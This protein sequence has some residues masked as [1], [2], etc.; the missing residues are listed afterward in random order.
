MHPVVKEKVNTMALELVSVNDVQVPAKVVKQTANQKETRK[1]IDDL[2]AAGPEIVGKITVEEGKMRSV[3]MGFIHGFKSATDK[4][5]K[6][7]MWESSDGGTLFIQV[8]KADAPAA[9]TNVATPTATNEGGA[10]KK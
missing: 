1:M 2:I 10:Q 8:V 5:L 6:P 9:P 3:K 7:K 4:Q